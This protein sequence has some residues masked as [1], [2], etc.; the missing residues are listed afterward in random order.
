MP[1][2]L[3]SHTQDAA[4]SAPSP[5]APPDGPVDSSRTDEA[6]GSSPSLPVEEEVASPEGGDPITF[7]AALARAS[8]ENPQVAFAN[9]RIREAFAQ[10]EQ[11][12]VLWL[13]SVRAGVSYNKHEGPLQ[14]FDGGVSRASR[15][16][17]ESG[18]G[19]GATGTGSPPVS[20]VV[21]SF[22]LADAMLQP[23]IAGDVT[24][25]RSHA[26]TAIAH[27][28]L[29]ST[30]LAYL[31]LLR[32]VQEETIAQ[33]TLEHARELAGMTVAFARAGQGSQADA[34]RAEA[35]LA[36]RQNAVA[37][38][39][40]A[41]KVA[42]ARLSELLHLDPTAFLVPDEP[43]IVPVDLVPRHTAVPEL[44]GQGLLNRPE[45]AE[46]RH[47]VSAAVNRLKRERCAPLIPSL[48]LGIS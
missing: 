4:P 5:P 47:L 17:L 42:S 36:V 29:L 18:L 13:P 40:E 3:A 23:R 25:A 43:G 37:R 38:A 28:L 35:E 48:L 33:E 45:L 1:I 21:A 31:D 34:D 39:E 27:D 14:E 9:E 6:E 12:K 19:V 46:S 26:A 20:G 41:T 7:A 2:R 11:A 8:G 44:V 32:A 15:T 30:A 10:Y 16:A 22:R 24:A